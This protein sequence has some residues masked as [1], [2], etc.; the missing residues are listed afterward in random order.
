MC[1]MLSLFS[2]ASGIA[3]NAGT[4]VIYTTWS[5]VSLATAFWYRE[6]SFNNSRQRNYSM[7]S[8]ACSKG[9]HLFALLYDLFWRHLQGS[10]LT[11][12]CSV[13]LSWIS[14]Y[15]KQACLYQHLPF[16]GTSW[17]YFDDSKQSFEG[18]S[19]SIWWK[20]KNQSDLRGLLQSWVDS[21]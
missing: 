15:H 11:L 8:E 7:I 6:L 17:I 2:P 13:A 10:L 14:S 12:N 16:H 19:S 20:S 4:T 5:T 9:Q 1:H 18:M 3:H 21:Q